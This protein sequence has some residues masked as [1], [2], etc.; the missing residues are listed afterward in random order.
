MAAATRHGMDIRERAL[1]FSVA[2]LRFCRQLDQQDFALRTISRQLARSGTSIGAN[3]EEAQAGETRSDFIH[4]N[5][6]AL[7]EA[8][9]A[10]YWLRLLLASGFAPSSTTRDLQQECEEVMKV[11]AAIIVSAKGRAA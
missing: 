7:K 8:R 10:R 6:L 2:L 9:E 5:A 4:K 3:L 1:E 11:L